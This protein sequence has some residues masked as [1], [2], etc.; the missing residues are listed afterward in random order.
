[1]RVKSDMG[2]SR[3]AVESDALDCCRRY[4]DAI[5]KP[6][7]RE[8]LEFT[9]DIIKSPD[10]VSFCWQKVIMPAMHQVGDLW[11]EGKITVGQ[12]HLATSITQ[13]VMS[14]FYPMILDAPRT[15]G[16]IVF[17]SSPGEL[18][19]VGARMIADL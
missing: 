4:L 8:A 3:M 11:A 13:R 6:N 1:M 7:S 5:L 12:E 17:V 15:K 16:K 18:H 19:D 9:R 10:D 14:A 2:D